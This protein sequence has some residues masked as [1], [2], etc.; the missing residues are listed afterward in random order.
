MSVVTYFIRIF[1]NALILRIVIEII[2]A[3]VV[4]GFFQILTKNPF[5]IDA[6]HRMK[7]KYYGEEH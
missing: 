1:I 3:V 2:I 4:Y 7:E 6:L 5:V